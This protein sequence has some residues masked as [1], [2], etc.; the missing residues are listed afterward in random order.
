MTSHM[1]NQVIIQ[2]TA[3]QPIRALI[4]KVQVGWF[5]KINWGKSITVDS[6]PNSED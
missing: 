2:E 6:V 1:V 5:V 3:S 4:A